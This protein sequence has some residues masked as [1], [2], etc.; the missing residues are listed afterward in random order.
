M[1]L[2]VFSLAGQALDLG[3]FELKSSNEGGFQGKIPLLDIGE[4]Q[5]DSITAEIAADTYFSD[6]EIERSA[7]LDGLEVYVRTSASGSHIEIIGNQQVN[8]KYLIA[9]L[10]VSWAGGAMLK[11]VAMLFD[12]LSP[13]ASILPVNVS[14]QFIFTKKNQ[15]LWRIASKTRPSEK[16]SVNQHMAAIYRL[17]PDAFIE[18]N[19]N[20]VKTDYKLTI[21]SELESLRFDEERAVSLVKG[22]ANRYSDILNRTDS[23]ELPPKAP[24]FAGNVQ[25]FAEEKINASSEESSSSWVLRGPKL[26]EEKAQLEKR[27]ADLTQ[28][29]SEER[30]YVNR[31]LLEKDEQIEALTTQVDELLMKLGRARNELTQRVNFLDSFITL[32]KAFFRG[33][34]HLSIYLIAGVTIV[35][36]IVFVIR[37]NSNQ[38]EEMREDPPVDV[39]EEELTL[40][41]EEVESDRERSHEPT[42]SP[43]PVKPEEYEHELEEESY[44]TTTKINLAKANIE[45]DKIEAAQEILK[46]VINEGDEHEKEQAEDLLKSINTNKSTKG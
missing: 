41:L 20:L 33:S 23:V 25:I 13:A 1:C 14:E 34:A 2:F 4:I 18:G 37:R 15:N 6:L 24:A 44:T 29:Y 39:S 22:Q 26:L 30:L 40:D 28:K 32:V 10:E 12:N 5:F 8:K 7:Y 17:N 11:E 43:S 3:Q 16:V 35:G 46:E 42:I 45:I 19:M 21:P 38:R 31:Q 27:I 36:L 9:L